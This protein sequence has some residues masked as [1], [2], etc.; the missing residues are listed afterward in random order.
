MEDR[1]A[2]IE[3]ILSEQEMQRLHDEVLKESQNV[4]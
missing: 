1:D 3:E 2:K 4:S